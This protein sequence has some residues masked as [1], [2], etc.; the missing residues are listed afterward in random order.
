MLQREFDG[1][2]QIALLGAAI[3]TFAV[4][5]IRQDRFGTHQLCNAVRQLQLTTSAGPKLAKMTKDRRCQ[6]VA[7]DDADV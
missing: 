7:T 2:L 5:L 3:M 1:G 4:E 6:D